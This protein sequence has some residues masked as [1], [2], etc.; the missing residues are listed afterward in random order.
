MKMVP[1]H[2]LALS[3]KFYLI[4][5]IKIISQWHSTGWPELKFSSAS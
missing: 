1:A 2:E 3:I 5:V 4:E